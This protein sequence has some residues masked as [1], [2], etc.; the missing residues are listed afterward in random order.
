MSQEDRPF[1]NFLRVALRTLRYKWEQVGMLV[2]S[3][4]VLILGSEAPI[5]LRV[6]AVLF[7]LLLLYDVGDYFLTRLRE[8]RLKHVPL[9]V[10]IGVNDDEYIRMARMVWQ[11]MSTPWNFDLH[12]YEEEYGLDR[13]RL[14]LHH[15]SDL[16][17]VGTRWLALVEKF[18]ERLVRL[19]SSLSGQTVLHP[20]LNCP[21]ALA[22]GLGAVAGTR[23]EIILHQLPQGGGSYQV[24]TSTLH[25]RQ[26]RG[27]GVEIVRQDAPEPFQYVRVETEPQ[28]PQSRLFVALHLGGYPLCA[29]IAQLAAAEGAAFA[30]VTNTYQG[31]LKPEDDWLLLVREVKTLV[32]RWL[33]EPA[34][35]RIELFLGGP[36]A[37]FFLVGMALGTFLPLTVHQ[38][39]PDAKLYKAVLKLDQLRRIG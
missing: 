5:I 22:L 9:F 34:V 12:R 26:Q 17:Q 37:L 23:Y 7:S 16:P 15:E 28:P 11:A 29:G 4:A 25:S 1:Q 14:S 39:F 31:Q 35:E 27:T 19:G 21:T 3:L 13:L 8:Q 36:V 10:A 38:W 20:F 33:R 24:V 18:G 30:C 32:A 6:L 2:F